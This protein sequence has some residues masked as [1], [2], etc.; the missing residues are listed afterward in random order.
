MSC[1]SKF[2]IKSKD[3]VYDLSNNP[4]S[5]LV[6]DKL[7]LIGRRL[8]K[9]REAKPRENI[10]VV[11]MFS[12]H[13]TL[14]DGCQ[15]VIFGDF[16]ETPD[17]FNG[18]KYIPR[19]YYK[20]IKIEHI[21]RTWSERYLNSYIVGIFACCRQLYNRESMTGCVQ[22]L[23]EQTQLMGTNWGHLKGSIMWPNFQQQS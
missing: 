6:Q 23:T 9:G 16:D 1:L 8:K 4:S 13:G 7:R 17:L 3:D 18:V 2:G 5:Q 20:I 21:L 14:M 11:C 15:S 19:D 10:L 22:V 12:C